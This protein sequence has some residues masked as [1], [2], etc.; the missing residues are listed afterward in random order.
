MSLLFHSSHAVVEDISGNGVGGIREDGGGGSD[1]DRGG[2]GSVSAA[3]RV[4]TGAVCGGYGMYVAVGSTSALIIYWLLP[5][6]AGECVL[7]ACCRNGH[8][9]WIDFV[10]QP[11]HS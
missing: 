3:N 1:G 5:L 11:C 6:M 2:G 8:E 10:T 9:V 7:H 4:I